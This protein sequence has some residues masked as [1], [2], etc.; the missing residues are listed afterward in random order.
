VRGRTLLAAAAALGLLAGCSTRRVLVIDSAPR[1][2]QVWVN[3]VPRGTTPTEVSFVHYGRFEVRLEREGHEALAEEVFIPSKIDG[4]PIVDLP[5]EILV[6]ERR[7]RW[8]GTLRPLRG[9]PTEADM[10]GV[11]DRA[12]E[13][14]ERT[15]RETRE[16]GTPGPIRR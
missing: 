12:K 14:R 1:G 6:R 13:F 9:R 8:T 2:A 11:L 16:P 10:A 7:F 5:F 4:Y 3:G 15:L